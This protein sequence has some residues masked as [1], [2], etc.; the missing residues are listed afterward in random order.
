MRSYAGKRTFL[1]DT[2]HHSRK[3]EYPEALLPMLRRLRL[4]M[5]RRRHAW[6]VSQS[7]CRFVKDKIFAG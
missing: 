1:T 2:S 7:S 4:L 6:V 5:L 3:S